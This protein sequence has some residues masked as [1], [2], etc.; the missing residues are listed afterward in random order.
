M[1]NS[2]DTT[3]TDAVVAPPTEQPVAKD[4]A[5]APVKRK[6]PVKRKPKAEPVSA[7]VA[8][9]VAKKVAEAA[10]VSTDDDADAA[11]GR[12]VVAREPLDGT[13]IGGQ[14]TKKKYAGV[15]KWQMRG[16]D[17]KEEAEALGFYKKGDICDHCGKVFQRLFPK[18]LHYDKKG[19]TQCSGKL[20][21]PARQQGKSAVKI[22]DWVK[23]VSSALLVL[24]EADEPYDFT[25]KD[26]LGFCLNRDHPKADTIKAALDCQMF[27]R[28]A[29]K[30]GI[31]EQPNVRVMTCVAF[32][33]GTKTDLCENGEEYSF[34][35]Y[36]RDW[37][38]SGSAWRY[39]EEMT[40]KHGVEMPDTD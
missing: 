24:G 3:K 37:S 31:E 4:N 25:A 40:E 17:S 21:R 30:K 34:A 26:F 5:K 16:Y 11:D 23:K 32:A 27:L 8:K 28:T 29:I 6:H 33:D 10:D 9:A 20:K 36:L 19:D 12:A 22:D 38:H 18:F 35:Q 13:E 15:A 1:M 39:I 7:A 14:T 2:T